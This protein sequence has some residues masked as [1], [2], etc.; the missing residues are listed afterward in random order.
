M[1]VAV[2]LEQ[3]WD[4]VPG[5]TGV[6]A[7]R[8]IEAISAHGGVDVVGVAGRHRRVLTA[9]WAPSVPIVQMPVPSR[10]VYDSWLRLRRPLVERYVPRADVVHAM[11][12]FAPATRRPLVVT[13]HDLAFLHD[14]SMFTRRGVGM[15]QRG[16]VAIKRHADLVLCSSFAT[17]DDASAAGIVGDRLRHVP[18]GVAPAAAVDPAEVDRVRRTHRLPQRYI[19]AV[20]TREPRKNLARL[21]LAFDRFAIEHPDIDLVVVGPSGWGD[22]AVPPAATAGRVHATGFVSDVDLCVIYSEALVFCYP[23]LREGFGLPILEAMAHG[24]PVVTS[25][26]TSTAEVAGEVGFLVDPTS[27]DDIASGLHDAVEHGHLRRSAALERAG[28]Y[29]WSATADR[30]VSAYDEVRA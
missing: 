23:S 4:P 26:G 14:A 8:M 21:F 27:V 3:L 25:A 5:G 12:I 29:N 7:L 22:D 18:L 1:L 16:L 30:V 17:M 20:G 11:S 28:G 6:A 9:P 2:T 19:L 10:L 24:L 15:F 13:L